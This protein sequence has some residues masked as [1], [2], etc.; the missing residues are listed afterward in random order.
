[1]EVMR[2]R[3]SCLWAILLASTNVGT[4]ADRISNRILVMY[5]KVGSGT[6]ARCI[7]GGAAFVIPLI[8]DYEYLSLEPIQIEVPL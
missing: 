5:G 2:P 6:S 8:Q 3:A 7:H 1:M 4:A